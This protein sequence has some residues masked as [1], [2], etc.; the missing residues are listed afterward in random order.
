MANDTNDLEI[1]T[2]SGLE[3]SRD[4]GIYCLMLDCVLESCAVKS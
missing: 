4:I 1:F 2:G 3:R